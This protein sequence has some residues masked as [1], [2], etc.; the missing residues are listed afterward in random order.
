MVYL[1]DWVFAG[2]GGDFGLSAGLL[3]G[4]GHPDRLAWSMLILILCHT[5]C[6]QWS[7]VTTARNLKPDIFTQ[8]PPANITA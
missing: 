5:L 1:S 3:L 4:K 7:P 6:G 8:Q 2:N